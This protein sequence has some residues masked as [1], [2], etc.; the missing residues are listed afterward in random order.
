M[1]KVLD[2]G[3]NT[4][5]QD[6]GRNGLYHLGVPPSGAADKYSF[7]LGNLLLGNPVHYAG[8]EMTLLGAAIEFRKKT[9][10][11]VTGAPMD[12]YLNHGKIPMWENVKVE[13]GDVL[14]FK[15]AQSGVRTYLCVSGG[16]LVPEMLGSKSTYSL[17]QFGA[18]I[19]KK[20]VNGTELGLGEPLPGVFKQVG[21]RIPPTYTPQFGDRVDIRVVMGL[22]S[23]R[24]SDEGIKAFLNTEWRV[25]AE[26]NRV[27]C[28]YKGA[29]ISYKKFE[30]PFGA[31]SGS[32]NVV[33]IAYPIGV[34]MVP[35]SEEIIMLLNDAT[36]GG[37]FVTVGTAISPDLDKV[38]QSRP[39]S[40][41]RFIAVT[42]DQAIT[43]R[44]EK[45]KKLLKLTEL[46]DGRP[47]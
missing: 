3:L 33:D 16:I 27:A 15:S 17:N 11:A 5:I 25:S 12:V 20:L 29:T 10:I 2:T 35:N 19:G 40:T 13:E 45:K 9:V 44:L 42:V 18:Y 1:L 7:Q 38:S 22:S 36:T 4:T 28:R 41:T 8:L 34:L 23:Y 47:I 37:G 39:N 21:K 14:S 30:P 46:L 43:A 24:L 31:G 32:S 6:M 26:S